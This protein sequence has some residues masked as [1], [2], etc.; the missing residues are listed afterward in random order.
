VED[1]A[2]LAEDEVEFSVLGGV[3]QGEA[4]VATLVG[5]SSDGTSFPLSGTYFADQSVIHP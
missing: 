3:G 2:V 1:P 4:A 5:H